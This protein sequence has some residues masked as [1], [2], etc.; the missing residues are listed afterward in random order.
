MSNDKMIKDHIAKNRKLDTTTAVA[1]QSLSDDDSAVADFHRVVQYLPRN[2]DSLD[3][4]GQWLSANTTKSAT[5]IAALKGMA[6]LKA[7]F[8][9]TATNN[10]E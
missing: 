3:R 1:K 2:V 6:H 5:E 4:F 7:Y 8:K 9:N 10:G